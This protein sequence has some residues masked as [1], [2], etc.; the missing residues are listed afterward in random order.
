MCI[1][2][3]FLV[4]IVYVIFLFPFYITKSGLF[5]V[6]FKLPVKCVGCPTLPR[7]TGPMRT[8]SALKALAKNGVPLT[9]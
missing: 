9:G 5:N 8:L 4:K 3:Y 2:L 7:A 6:S 1:I